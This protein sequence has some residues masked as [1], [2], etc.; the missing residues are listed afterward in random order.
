MPN[1]FK[2]IMEITG[3][4]PTVIDAD[5]LVADPNEVVQNFC[6]AIDIPFHHSQLTW[7]KSPKFISK[8][9]EG[10]FS[11]IRKEDRQWLAELI[12]ENQKIC[13][14]LRKYSV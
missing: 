11:E 12:A 4:P 6:F 8:E 14:D 1:I 5:R 9:S 10:R 7:P 2:E 13:D 3:Q